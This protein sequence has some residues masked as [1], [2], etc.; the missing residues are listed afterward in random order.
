MG[1]SG[2][3]FSHMHRHR[4]NKCP[5]CQSKLD[6]SSGENTPPKKGDFTICYY[7]AEILVYGDNSISFVRTPTDQEIE[8]AMGTDVCD[9][10]LSVQKHIKRKNSI[11]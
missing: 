7:C 2:D 4:S 1:N 5:S 6:A 10:V 3:L 11:N 8:D 9:L